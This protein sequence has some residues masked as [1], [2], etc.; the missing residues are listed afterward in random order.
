MTQLDTYIE[1]FLTNQDNID[2]MDAMVDENDIVRFVAKFFFD[3]GYDEGY[4]DR[5]FSEFV[6]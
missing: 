3:C 1:N 5:S 2:I 4:E 6:D